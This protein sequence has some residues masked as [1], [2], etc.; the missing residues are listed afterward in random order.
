M[1]LKVMAAWFI[2]AIG[3][4]PALL[5]S[6]DIN[7]QQQIE[8][9]R[10]AGHYDAAIKL[11]TSL[12]SDNTLSSPIESEVMA[13]RLYNL[14]LLQFEAEDNPGARESFQKSI[15]ISREL[16][17]Q[18][19][20]SLVKPLGYLGIV[21]VKLGYPELGI[22]RLQEAQHLIHRSDGVKSIQQDYLLSW[23]SI[24]SIRLN[25]AKTADVLQRFRYDIFKSNF[26]P[27]HPQ[28]VPALL[29][30]ANWFKVSAQYTEAEQTYNRA[31]E[32]GE[33]HHL[34]TSTIQMAL[35]GLADTHYL[36][37]KCCADEYMTE[38]AVIIGGDKDYDNMEK[39]LAY[40][41]AADMSLILN[42]DTESGALYKEAWRYGGNLNDAQYNKPA[43]LGISR[44]DRIIRAYRPDNVLKVGKESYKVAKK[45]E[46]K[47]NSAQLVGAPLPFCASELKDLSRNR[48]YSGYVVDVN[49][50][51]MPD[52]RATDIKV[53]ETNTPTAISKLVRR[54]VR[55]YRF[56][57]KLSAGKPV[58]EEMQLRQTF[59]QATESADEQFAPAQIAAAHGCNLLALN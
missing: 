20:Q 15:E 13:I 8:N 54:I 19:S 49:F 12:I 3:S 58:S 4:Y 57:P 1:Y 53:V 41:K 33:L 47:E 14:G 56:R 25:N 51:V 11:Q 44:I 9:Y 31:R 34:P 6:D 39:S 18:F 21:L 23:M 59:S 40:V 26:G 30:L 27:S 10:L 42:G 55:L 48:D 36:K 2:I 38:A 45:S 22:D 16:V 17:G 35:A 5:R 7:L 32:L 50:Q 24:A 37:G 28:T 29:T 52:G 43:V 46:V